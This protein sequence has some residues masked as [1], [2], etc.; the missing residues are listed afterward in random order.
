[1][2]PWEMFLKIVAK[3]DSKDFWNIFYHHLDRV[4]FAARPSLRYL[5]VWNTEVTNVPSKRLLSVRL[6]AELKARI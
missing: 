3:N 4:D 1:M 2:L 5:S 6:C